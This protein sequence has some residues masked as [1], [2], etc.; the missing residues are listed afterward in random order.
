[1]NTIQ[2][3]YPYITIRLLLQT[4]QAINNLHNSADLEE[5]AYDFTSQALM[6]YQD[7]LCDTEERMRSIKLITATLAHLKIFDEE[8]YNAL[9]MNTQQYCQTLLL[10]SSQCEALTLA[11]HMFTNPN[12]GIDNY[13]SQFNKCYS[14]ALKISDQCLSNPSNLALLVTI[15]N[16]YYYHYMNDTARI[17]YDE[18]NKL[19]ELV[20]EYVSYDGKGA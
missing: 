13:T 20:Q 11:S 5:L 1:M 4:T 16:K 7:E 14:K 10:K 6:I 12:Y 15:L 8:N 17:S 19:I 3:K 2:A 18:V 9:T